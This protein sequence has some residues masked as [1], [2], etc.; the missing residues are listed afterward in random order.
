M[1]VVT[2]IPVMVVVKH[3][4]LNIES[5]DYMSISWMMK[6]VL[7]VPVRIR[8]VSHIV[9]AP[10]AVVPAVVFPPSVPVI[11]VVIVVMRIIFFAFVVVPHV[12]RSIIIFPVFIAATVIAIRRITSIRFIDP[13]EI[14]VFACSSSAPAV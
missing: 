7:V 10:A 5:A 4:W 2:I 11:T 3:K 12:A 1:P 6:V 8:I 9:I 13:I 14:A